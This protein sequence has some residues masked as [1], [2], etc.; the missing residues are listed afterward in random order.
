MVLNCHL[1]DIQNRVILVSVQFP[2]TGN[3]E[4]NTLIQENADVFSKKGERNGGRKT[5]TLRIKT[6]DPTICQT[7]YR[8]P[9]NKR[10]IVE[11][12]I[13]DMLSEGVIRPSNSP[14][15]SHFVG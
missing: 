9:L 5:S 6:T 7:A 10:M 15:F 3:A 12:M 11:D 2:E 8:M 4:I 13:D 1:G 14:Y